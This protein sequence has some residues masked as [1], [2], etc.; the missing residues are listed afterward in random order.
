MDKSVG[1][2]PVV[3]ILAIIAFSSLLG[4]PGAI[5][6]IPLAAIIQVV[7]SYMV[8]EPQAPMSQEEGRGRA[9]VL[10]Y[11]AQQLRQDVQKQVRD[12]EGAI[13]SDSE[14]VEDLIESIA[15]DV[16]S[17]LARQDASDAVEA[18]S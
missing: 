17:L 7:V 14:K 16:D 11:E 1:V 10:R 5:L 15:S 6:A 12:K 8:F 3:T 18:N 13:D 4:L 9:S 2:N